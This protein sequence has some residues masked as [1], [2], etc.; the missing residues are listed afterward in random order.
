MK[1]KGEGVRGKRGDRRETR[2]V[3]SKIALTLCSAD[4]GAVFEV[5]PKRIEKGLLKRIEKGIRAR[6]NPLVVYR[7]CLFQ[8]TCLFLFWWVLPYYYH[9]SFS[10]PLKE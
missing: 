2:I 8:P 9:W 5:L 6:G 4:T 3:K 10:P 1:E 7:A